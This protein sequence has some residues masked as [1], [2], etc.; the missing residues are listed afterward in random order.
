MHLKVLISAY[1]CEPEKGSEPGVGWNLTCQVAR[2]HEVWLLTRAKNCPAIEAALAQESSA[3]LHMVYF[4]LPPWARFWK[5]G[6]RGIHLYYYLW[7]VGAYIKA[8]KLHRE[9]GFDVVHHLTFGTDWIPSFLA[10]LPVPFVWGPIVGAQ[11]TNKALRQTFPWTAKIREFARMWVRQLSRLDPLMRCTAGRTAL[12]LASGLE[13]KEHLTRLGCAKVVI[14]PSVGISNCEM[15][16]LASL[17]PQDETG[18]VRFLSVGR[19]VAFRGL[20]LVLEALAQVRQRFPQVELW[21]I[22]EGPERGRLMRQAERLGVTDVVKFW[23][24]LPR[25]E[26]LSRLP[27]CNTFVHLCFRGAVS[28]ACTEAMAARLPVICLDLGGLGLQ[29][30]EETGIKV[31]AVSPEQVVVD[32]AAAMMR[33]AQDPA[34]RFRLGQAGQQRVAARFDWEQKGIFMAN[35]Y[36]ALKKDEIDR[37]T[38]AS[39]D[40]SYSALNKPR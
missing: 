28:M 31:P 3:N 36:E 29:V 33:L 12:A 37:F 16:H 7:Q 21:I 4:D 34:L 22:G 11:S 9:V 13:A 8:R 38:S 23:G 2:Y 39:G 40:E 18:K 1:A 6:D 25:A 14:H 15:Q 26:M 35:L 17:P 27:E 20:S 5:K 10:L 19:L 32:L 30:T 24:R